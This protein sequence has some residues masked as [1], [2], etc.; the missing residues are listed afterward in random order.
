MVIHLPICC[1]LFSWTC[2]NV[3]FILWAT[4]WSDRLP[5]DDVKSIFLSFSPSVFSFCELSKFRQSFN[6]NSKRYKSSFLKALVFYKNFF[7]VEYDRLNRLLFYPFCVSEKIRI[8][9]GPVVC[10]WSKP[11]VRFDTLAM[12]VWTLNEWFW[13]VSLSIKRQKIRNLWF[14]ACPFASHPTFFKT[15][16]T[17]FFV[18]SEM[19]LFMNWPN[20]N[21]FACIESK[22]LFR[23]IL[24]KVII[25]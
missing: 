23:I 6:D 20:D 2:Q 5:S 15:D 24:W 3:A 16:Q 9:C 4:D 13:F 21:W 8:C 11:T 10:C 14:K 7:A 22:P 12:G 19:L 18:Q 17:M 25:Q 1:P